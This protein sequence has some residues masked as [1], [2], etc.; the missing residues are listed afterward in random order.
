[1]KKIF[2]LL[3]LCLVAVVMFV[4]YTFRKVFN[5]NEKDLS[6][7]ATENEEKY[8]LKANYP[9]RKTYVVQRYMDEVLRTNKTF[10]NSRMDADIAVDKLKLHVITRPGYLLLKMNKAENDSIVYGH[11]KQL[12][13]GLQEKLGGD[14]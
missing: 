13:K 10:T 12:E 2:V 6:I 1:M 14:R 7:T 8:E 4:N 11:V 3:V 9:K 5:G